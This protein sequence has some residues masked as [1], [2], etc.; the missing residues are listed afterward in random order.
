MASYAQ[1][2]A[3]MLKLCFPQSLIARVNAA[4]TAEAC[5]DRKTHASFLRHACDVLDEAMARGELPFSLYRDLMDANACCKGGSRDRET[6]AIGREMAGRSLQEKLD[7]LKVARNMMAPYMDDDGTILVKMHCTNGKNFYC[8]CGAI[9]IPHNEG[10]LSKHY[11][12]C[13]AGHFHHHYQNALQEKLELVEIVSS[14]LESMGEQ[15]FIARFRVIGVDHA[16]P[17]R[18]VNEGF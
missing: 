7:A 6:K 10:R 2:N 16:M 18:R 14:P 11:C 4:Y 12:M 5:K 3:H 13:C 9:H 8:S 15:P 17:P 1:M